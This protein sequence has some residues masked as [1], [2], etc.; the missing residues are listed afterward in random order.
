MK[1]PLKSSNNSTFK[2]FRINSLL[3]ISLLLISGCSAP[4]TDEQENRLPGKLLP[5]ALFITSGI[6]D[7]EP[8]LAQGIVIAIQS[9]NKHGVPVRLETRDILYNYREMSRY[10]I[11][12]LSTFPGY[13]DADRRNSLSYMSD[14]ELANLEKFVRNGGMII[15]GDNVGRN[16]SDGTDRTTLYHELTPENW[17]L[18]KCYGASLTEKDVSGFCLSDSL[19]WAT[20]RDSSSGRPVLFNRDVWMLVPG[21]I[22]S[23]SAEIL[24]SISGGQE[25]FPGILKNKYQKGMAFFLVS[26]GFLH[27]INEGGYWSVD[28]IEK[29]YDYVIDTYEDENGIR[30]SLNPWPDAASYAF[31]VTLNAEGNHDQ[32]ERVFRKLDEEDI[33]PTIFVAGIKDQEVRKF[34]LSRNYPLASSGFSFLKFT[35]LNYPVT[36]EEILRNES[37]WDINFTGFRFPYTQPTVFGMIALEEN[38]YKFESSIGANNLDFI[39]GAVVPYNLVVSQ[40][41]FYRRTNILEIAPTYHD[42]YYFLSIIGQKSSPDSNDLTK[43]VRV[44]SEYLKDFWIYS[45]KP[46][47]GVM[48]FLGHPRFVGYNDIT[49]TSLSDLIHEVKK[50]HAWLASMDQVAEFR[51]GLGAMEFYTAPVVNGFDIRIVA[52]DDIR[53]HGVCLN[54]EG[55]VKNVSTKQGKVKIIHTGDRSQLIFEAF[56]GQTI[57]IRME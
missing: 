43:N 39:H 38:G 14:E 56:D 21:K 51:S 49:L 44:Y 46:Y 35:E 12:V 27:P 16:Y 20:R 9:L 42:D 53:L 23:D 36:V 48:V 11:I 52:P 3:L 54:V 55:K 28:E 7:E 22:W 50:D 37:T 5:K 31:C 32:Y 33:C 40:E 25:T 57:K 17:A 30:A 29:F 41:G 1:S 24:V 2:A 8:R 34:L 13:H 47:K 18:S 6:S 19:P 10:A 4:I 45:V 26:S 15:A